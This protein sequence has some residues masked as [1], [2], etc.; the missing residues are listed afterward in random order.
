MI[1]SF[2]CYYSTQAEKK[3]HFFEKSLDF[4]DQMF[5]YWGVRLTGTLG[6]EAR[7]YLALFNRSPVSYVG[8]RLAGGRGVN[9]G[10]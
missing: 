6:W 3:L 5:Y 10:T 2:L 1:F 8:S 7:R 9:Y 4:G